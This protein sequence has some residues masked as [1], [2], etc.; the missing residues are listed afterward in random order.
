MRGRRGHGKGKRSNVSDDKPGGCSSVWLRV[1]DAR[2]LGHVP[3]S[4]LAH[5]LACGPKSPRLSDFS[6][7]TSR[8][9][10]RFTHRQPSG[11]LFATNEH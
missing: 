11:F 5:R 10:L 4:P 1:A 7:K 6:Q 9:L 2:V 8:V 3:G